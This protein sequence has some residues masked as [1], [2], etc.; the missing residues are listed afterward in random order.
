MSLINEGIF[1]GAPQLAL[2][3][4]EPN[5]QWTTVGYNRQTGLQLS[6]MNTGKAAITLNLPPSQPNHPLRVE[7]QQLCEKPLGAIVLSPAPDGAYLK[8]VQR[9]YFVLI[10]LILLCFSIC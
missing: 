1:G 5:R 8:I 3:P 2:V 9:M 4:L 6:G 7:L 10:C